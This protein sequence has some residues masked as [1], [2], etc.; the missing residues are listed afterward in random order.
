MAGCGQYQEP[1]RRTLE[2][3]S[4]TVGKRIKQGVTASDGGRYLH[5]SAANGHVRCRSA[6]FRHQSRKAK[7]EDPVKTRFGGLDSHYLPVQG[8][9]GIGAAIVDHGYVS[10]SCLGR[11]E[12]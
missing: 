6:V 10:L 5:L 7:S 12:I 3:H 11:D 1:L 9:T 2:P 8:L 4:H